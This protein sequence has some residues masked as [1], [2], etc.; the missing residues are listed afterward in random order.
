MTHR[1]SNRPKKP[2]AAT[3]KR[4]LKVESCHRRCD[5]CKKLRMYVPR[6]NHHASKSWTGKFTDWRKEA[7]GS[8]TC[9]LCVARELG[10][11]HHAMPKKEQER[12]E[13]A[14]SC[15]ET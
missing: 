10:I 7:D 12:L 15:K 5:R 11:P 9:F 8:R 2:R 14:M 3:V 4:A 13:S 6:A 1:E